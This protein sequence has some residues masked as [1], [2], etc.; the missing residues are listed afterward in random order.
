MQYGLHENILFVKPL[1]LQGNSTYF[2]VP[3]NYQVLEEFFT[4][5]ANKEKKFQYRA[6]F[7]L[8][9]SPSSLYLTALA[10]YFAV[11]FFFKA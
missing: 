8:P 2:Q 9:S 4:A 10:V 3:R 11:D 1:S 7:P 6:S 5:E